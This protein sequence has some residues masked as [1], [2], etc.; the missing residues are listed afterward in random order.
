MSH[1][2]WQEMQVVPG[3]KGWLSCT[4]ARDAGSP[5]VERMAL[6]LWGKRCR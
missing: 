5:W 3:W 6:M 4:E 2:L 1:A